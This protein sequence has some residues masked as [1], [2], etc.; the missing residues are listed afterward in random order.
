MRAPRALAIALVVALA[1][2]GAAAAAADPRARV[3]DRPGGDKADRPDKPDKRER[4]R[5]RIRAMRALILA[6]ELQLD[7]ATAARLAPIL[8][9]YDDELARLLAERA[10]LR[11]ELRA[12]AAARDARRIDRT[13]DR[14]VTNQDARWAAERRRF[15]ELRRLLSPAQTAR[16]LD[17]LPEIDRRI[18]RG[19]RRDA[20]PRRGGLDPRPR[21]RGGRSGPGPLPDGAPAIP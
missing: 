14:L 3:G 6:E 8:T 11:D 4:A 18:L 15:A 12:A 9:R 5:Q 17:V 1:A 2:G 19:L 13:V 10:A 16:L 7:E 20:A 21:R